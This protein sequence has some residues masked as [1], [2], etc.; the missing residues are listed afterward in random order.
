MADDGFA[1]EAE[2]L[3][4]RADAQFV[5]AIAALQ[6]VDFGMNQ[7]FQFGGTGDRPLDTFVHCRNF[8][9]DG[10]ADRHDA[11]G[12]CGFR[13]GQAQS[14]FGHGAGGAAQFLGARNHDGK[15]EKQHHRQDDEDRYT[16]GTRH[17]R[18]VGKR[19]DLPDFRAVEK[20]G[21]TK[22]TD[23]P[24]GGDCC[25]DAHRR[26]AGADVQRSQ[27]R[28]RSLAAIVVCWRK[29]GC[30]GGWL[31]RQV[32]LGFG[33][34]GSLGCLFLLGFLRLRLAECR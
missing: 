5:V 28:G 3:N 4:Q 34:A 11:F 20:I 23:D 16:D 2:L 21:D 9:A 26:A 25:S 32:S 14:D 18:Q 12:G 10:L 19:A 33:S 6:R 30:L 24:Q 7:G 1:L 27:D 15:G 17:G 31:R 22:A 29:R 8:A 13:L